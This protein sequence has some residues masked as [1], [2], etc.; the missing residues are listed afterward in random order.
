MVCL[1]HS[2]IGFGR[3]FHVADQGNVFCAT[4]V[5]SEVK[6]RLCLLIFSYSI[7]LLQLCSN[8]LIFMNPGFQRILNA[9]WVAV[10]HSRHAC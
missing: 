5:T 3:C 9:V 2:D 4:F 10:S 6:V 1:C 7:Y 8:I